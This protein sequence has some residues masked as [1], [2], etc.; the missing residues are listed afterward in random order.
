MKEE[1]KAI[2][3]AIDGV[4]DEMLENR[5]HANMGDLV[6][7]MENISSTRCSISYDLKDLVEQKKHEIEVNVALAK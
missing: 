7:V 6:K 4:A 5:R 3:C 1:L 2:R